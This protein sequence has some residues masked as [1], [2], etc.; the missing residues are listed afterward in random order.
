MNLLIATTSYPD[1]SEG[2]AAAGV[3]VRDFVRALNEQGHRV[4]IVAPGAE[5]RDTNEQ[6]IL[7]KRFMVPKQPLSL[8]KPQKPSDWPAIMQTLRNGRRAV[9][10]ACREN[11]F[12]HILALWVLPSGMWARS[13][14]KRSG[15]PYS[16]WALGSDIWSLGKV[17]V[18]RQLLKWVLRGARYRYA[19]GFQLAGDVERI[20]GMD[21]SFLPSARRLGVSQA[22]PV[23]QNPP[24][25]L[26]FLG[27]W[28]PNKGIDLL[29]EA[30]QRL[31]DKDWQRIEAVRIFGG[32]PME[33]W[34]RT[35][36]EHLKE[37][38]RPV[39]IGGY[40]NRNEAAD[41]LSWADFV[42]IPSRIES[43]PVIFSDAMQMGLPVIAMPVGDLP[44]LINTH[45]CGLV[46]EQVTAIALTTALQTALRDKT[47]T[48]ADGIKAACLRFDINESARRFIH[49]L[50]DHRNAGD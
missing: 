34:V 8:L 33:D 2:E 37:R 23:S 26:A 16:T 43:I 45:R 13:A 30:L 47:S 39:E 15:I 9:Y 24:Y 20:S 27:R 49:D 17:P 11:R 36:G 48:Y 1:A 46:A 25:R 10:A 38:G 31:T 28:H 29:L 42:V 21:C 44:A 18:V 50:E 12:D 3:F 41:L 7:V 19:D 5:Q 6:G 32:G 40:L 35:K 14:A 4:G 22:R